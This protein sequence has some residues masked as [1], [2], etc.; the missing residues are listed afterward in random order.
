[1]EEQK[2]RQ[3][4][5]SQQEISLALVGQAGQGLQVI[6]KVLTTVLAKQGFF[7]FSSKEY[8]SRVRG[9]M[10]STTIRVASHPVKA[11]KKKVDIALLLHAGAEEHIRDR[12]T[13][14][15]LLLGDAESVCDEG[16]A[17]CQ[18]RLCHLPLLEAARK[19]GDE[20]YANTIAAGALLALFEADETPFLEMLR[21]TF[22]RKGEE[23]VA[24]NL[25]AA[26]EGKKLGTLLRQECG[27][28]L[29]LSP[30]RDAKRDLFLSGTHAVAL[31]AVG[32]GCTM[33]A[34]Y[35]M[36]PSTGVLVTL[37]EYSQDLDIVVEQ[38]E[39]EI[40]CANMA[41]GAW[42]AGGRAIVTTSGGGFALMTETL[43]LSGM[44]ETPLVIHIAQRPGPA[45]GLPT[46]TEQ[47]DLLF[48]VHAGHGEFARVV[49]APGNVEEGFLLTKYAFEVADRF[50]VPV[51]ILTDQYFVDSS[52]NASSQDFPLD[53]KPQ[54]FVQ[55]TR[56]GYRRYQLTEDG[57]SPRGIPG[58][59]KGFVHVDSDEHDED[60]R[61][62]ESHEVRRAMVEKRLKRLEALRREAALPSI[63]HGNEEAEVLLVGWG[64]TYEIIREARE[65][66]G[67]DRL[68]QMH[69]R[70]VYPIPEETK[71]RYLRAK[72][73]VVVE[74]N[75]TGQLA[76]LLLQET[77]RKADE[78]ILRYDGSP[79][80]VDELTEKFRSLLSL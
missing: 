69:L 8:M 21:K 37:A 70:Q 64:S 77:G 68:A 62:T 20:I 28:T 66:L 53:T 56:E 72:R 16:D 48:A 24:K 67:D 44:T 35:P 47:G 38:V 13:P 57:I 73:V 12:M 18:S 6:E 49:L 2:K 10:N 74:N 39:D 54:R 14:E 25:Q 80:F 15:T 27:V 65:H 78:S 17:A 23:V 31:G 61:I 32:G 43:S 7:V 52:C 46:R 42:Y 26:H 33:I 11:L 79:F 58:W 60:G 19:V 9:G 41:L 22:A 63:S 59:G 55:E 1:M 40:G 51:L 4:H 75:A 71:E 30:Q 5:F 45:T 76:R 29:S 36:S 3:Y 34:S 50:Q